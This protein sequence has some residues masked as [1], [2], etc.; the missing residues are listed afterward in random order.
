M[1]L[2]NETATENHSIV[3]RLAGV[4]SNRNGYGARVE[5]V[6]AELA[7]IRELTGGGSFQAASAP[8]IHLGLGGKN[9]ATIRI[10]WPSG[11]V[12][13][14]SDLSAGRWLV[15]EGGGNHRLDR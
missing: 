14:H 5:V 10:R 7:M 11:R 8:E 3:L 15:V 12:D 2:R 1:A 6:G 4:A 9:E 13:V